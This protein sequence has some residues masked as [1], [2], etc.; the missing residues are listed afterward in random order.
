MIHNRILTCCILS[1][2]IGVY[3]NAGR[4]HAVASTKAFTTQVTALAL[5]AGWFSQN[6]S[7]EGAEVNRTRREE[8]LE[9]V[10]RLPIATRTALGTHTQ[11]KDLAEKLKG[12]Q[13]LFILGS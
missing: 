7:L 8:V 2:S 10:R 11:C 9:A 5:I 12:S 4:E 1:V 13:H 6:R 3:L